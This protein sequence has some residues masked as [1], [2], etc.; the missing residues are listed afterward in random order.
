MRVYVVVTAG[1]TAALPVA[2]TVPTPLSTMM[3]VALDT[4]HDSV[5]EPPEVTSDALALNEVIVGKLPVVDEPN[6]HIQE[7]N[8]IGNNARNTNASKY[9]YFIP[10]IFLL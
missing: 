5:A 2:F 3:A 9:L 7:L 10:E 4:F 8:M 1:V 6:G